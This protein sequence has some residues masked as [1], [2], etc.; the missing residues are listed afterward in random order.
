MVQAPVFASDR[1]LGLQILQ[2]Q[3]LQVQIT[4]HYAMPWSAVAR[5][6][7]VKTFFAA[8]CNLTLL[9][10]FQN[11]QGVL[12]HSV[13]PVMGLKPSLLR[14]KQYAVTPLRHSRLHHF[15]ELQTHSRS[16]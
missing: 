14:T 2:A 7:M 15:F 8:L 3:A 10:T 4:P 16:I 13:L 1:I 9:F 5:L 12:F 11:M 6:Q